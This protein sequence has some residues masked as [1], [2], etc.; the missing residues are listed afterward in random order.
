MH[1]E[2][3]EDRG[4]W[5]DLL[6][7]S[8]GAISLVLAGGVALYAITV[9]VIGALL[10]ALT[11]ELGA[12]EL[13]AWVNTAYLTASVL[14]SAMT[15]R[16]S[17]RLGTRGAYTLAFLLF[18]AGSLIITLAPAMSIVVAGRFVQGLGGG[19]LAALAYV[20][21]SALLPRAVWTRATVLITAMWAIGGIAGPAL[22]GAFAAAGTWR[23]AFIILTVAAGV[24][25][26]LAL[27]VIRVPRNP[28]AA[29]PGLAAASLALIVAG[30]VL[31][32]VATLFSG[33]VQGAVI[34]AGVLALVLFVAVDVRAASPLLPAMT[35][36]RG[37]QL[38]WVYLVIGLLAGSVMIEA[39][40]PL[41]AHEIGNVPALPAGYL[42]AVPSLGWTIAE[43]F[44]A[45]IHGERA[46]L[47]ARTVA[48]FLTVAGLIGFALVSGTLDG[49]AVLTGWIVSLAL[50]GIGVGLG[51]PHLS[52]AAMSA[53]EG[54][55]EGALAAA[56][57]ST[58]QL[59]SN[60]IVTALA[61]ILLGTTVAGLTSAQVVSGGLAILVAVTIPAALLIARR[62]RTPAHR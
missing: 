28:D 57:V 30:A 2:T 29:V 44:S 1:T 26:T 39:F 35:F 47:R 33:L 18:A 58:V 9:Y 3:T 17:I 19:F 13:Y 37:S 62:L 15:G 42:G 8:N 20:S 25:G 6:R 45:M 36:R 5:A 12:G 31:F 53:V 60:T 21:I 11:A 23:A 34:A 50:I 46:R 27:L 22:G 32:S 7:G 51:F 55:E 59:L 16:V 10:P 56:G 4:S 54:E 41:F 43:V 61:G 24:L 38:R 49:G 52:V 14:A 48:P 40:V